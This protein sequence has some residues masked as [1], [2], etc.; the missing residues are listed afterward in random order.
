MK[1]QWKTGKIHLFLTAFSFSHPQCL[2]TLQNIVE[3][4]FFY[5]CETYIK[6]C[7][8]QHNLLFLPV[9]IKTKKIVLVQLSRIFV[10][11]FLSTKHE[12]TKGKKRNVNFLKNIFSR[13]I[14]WVIF[15]KYLF[16]FISEKKMIRS[17]Q[18]L[19]PIKIIK[20]WFP[21]KVDWENGSVC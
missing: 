14:R 10:F 16:N 13:C 4:F 7:R 9:I 18:M 8:T 20:N 21:S 2:K 5:Q 17:N 12:D 3:S 1:M 19:I 15:I 6:G 11:F